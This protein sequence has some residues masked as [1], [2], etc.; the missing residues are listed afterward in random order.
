MSLQCQS[1][2]PT[3]NLSEEKKQIDGQCDSKYVYEVVVMLARENQ[4][5]RAQFSYSHSQDC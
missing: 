5:G 4:A 2:I 1:L 3:C